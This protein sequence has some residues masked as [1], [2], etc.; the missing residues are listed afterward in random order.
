MRIIKQ[1]IAAITLTVFSLLAGN[2]A[3]L[4]QAAGPSLRETLDFIKG[5]LAS[6]NPSYTFIY[7]DITYHTYFYEFIYEPVNFDTPELEWKE[8]HS[9][10]SRN[11]KLNFTSETKTTYIIKVN[12]RDINPSS[13]NVSKCES[14]S[15]R[16]D[17]LYS[18]TCFNIVMDTY[19]S[20]K[21]ITHRQVKK[22]RHRSYTNENSVDNSE[23]RWVGSELSIKFPEEGTANR[24]AKAL[25]HAV[26]LAGGRK[27]AF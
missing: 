13:I 10:V 26:T 24:V 5:K 12:L 23:E 22:T 4:A 9:S 14:N 11:T 6:S 17:G 15:N 21:K 27:E 7:T 18:G 2:Q 25:A 8:V 16:T 19:N 1:S 3:A 20:E